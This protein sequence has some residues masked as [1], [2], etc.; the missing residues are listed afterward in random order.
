MGSE[1]RQ[2][3]RFDVDWKARVLLPNKQLS[4]VGIFS[5]SRGGLAI[6]FGYAIPVGTQVNVEF[7]VNYRNENTRIR[8]VTRVVYNDI[9]AGNRG[10]KVG[11]NFQQMSSENMHALANALHAAGE[12]SQL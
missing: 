5:A 1:R 11:L 10:A 4:E 6:Y 8:A 9:M 7:Y 2:H 12:D 3:Q